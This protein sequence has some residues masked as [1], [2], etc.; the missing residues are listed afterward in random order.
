MDKKLY[1]FA[2]LDEGTQEKLKLYEKIILENGFTGQQTKNMPYHITL[3]SYSLEFENTLKELLD[4]IEA[5]FKQI[6][7]PYSGFGLFG[8]NVLYL[9]PLMNLKLL[10]LYNFIRGIDHSEYD[11]F[12]AH[13]TLIVD[14]PENIMKLLPQFV[15]KSGSITG[16]IKHISLYELFPKKLIKRIELKEE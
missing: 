7:V 15:E 1:V 2:E 8:L 10:E 11:G 4:K 9:N 14:E 13:T 12:S 5:N 16:I 6:Y 3:Q